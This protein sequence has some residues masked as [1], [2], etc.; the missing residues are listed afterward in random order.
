[1]KTWKTDLDNMVYIIRDEGILSLENICDKYDKQIVKM[2]QKRFILALQGLMQEVFKNTKVI[3][4]DAKEQI[5]KTYED[6]RDKKTL[7]LDTFYNGTYNIEITRLFEIVD[8]KTKFIRM[9]NRKNTPSIHSQLE[10]IQPGDYI[11]VDDDAVGGRTIREVIKL[12]PNGVNVTETYLMMDSYRNKSNEPILDVIDC[13]DFIIGST[14]GLTTQVD[15]LGILRLP[16]VYPFID[17][18][19]KAN[20]PEGQEVKVSQQIWKLNRQ[21]WIDI[22]SNATLEDTCKDFMLISEYI[23]I[24]RKTKIKDICDTYI[25]LAKKGLILNRKGY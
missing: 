14:G 4:I 18:D 5:D 20:I 17:I 9:V 10:V 12:L 22:D 25:K 23:G 6:L 13:R 2:A 16:Y 1:M 7:S 21:F 15:N 24:S 8:N 11:L 19:D 3:V